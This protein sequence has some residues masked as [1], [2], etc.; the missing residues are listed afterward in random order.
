LTKPL[1]FEELLAVVFDRVANS[2]LRVVTA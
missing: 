2:A 1:R